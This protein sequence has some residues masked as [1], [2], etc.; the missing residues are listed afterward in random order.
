MSLTGLS[1]LV[2]G[3]KNFIDLTNPLIYYNMDS[4]KERRTTGGILGYSD[5]FCC[6][7]ASL[8]FQNRKS[9]K[10]SMEMGF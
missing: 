5:P 4:S 7:R 10:Y 6:V 9:E 2:N 1:F 3:K 8:L